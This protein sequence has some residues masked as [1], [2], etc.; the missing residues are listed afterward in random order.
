MGDLDL[1]ARIDSRTLI[2]NRSTFVS[3]VEGKDMASDSEPQEFFQAF[4]AV[5]PN[6]A[7]IDRYLHA[8]V[9][10]YE[11][12]ETALSWET[13]VAPPL[14][15]SSPTRVTLRQRRATRSLW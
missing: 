15:G 5:T 10:W 2:S 13:Y 6:H 3:C 4:I 11:E 1:K 8:R 7:I 12:T 14:L 9:Q